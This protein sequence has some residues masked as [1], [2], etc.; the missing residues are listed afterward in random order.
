MEGQTTPPQ[1]SASP[2]PNA[3]GQSETNGL[4]VAAL[5]TGLLGMAIVPVILGVLGLRKPGGRGMSI[6]GIILGAL[7]II[8]YSIIIIVLVIAA[9]STGNKIKKEVDKQSNEMSSLQNAKKDFAAGETG[10]F[11][12][13]DV[14]INN[15]QRGYVPASEFDRAENGKELIVL[16]ISVTNNGKDSE[17]F[18]DYDLKVDHNGSEETPSFT[19]AP[20][21]AFDGGS[22]APGATK[23]GQLVYEVAANAQGLKLVYESTDFGMLDGKFQTVKNRYSL[24]F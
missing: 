1:A 14:K 9:A 24:A 7:Q 10:K 12:K 19:D 17:Y 21:T 11:G 5:I 20:G 23:T 15:V 18:S 16:D 22:L 6:A 13:F 2:Q 3:S 4:A 8:A